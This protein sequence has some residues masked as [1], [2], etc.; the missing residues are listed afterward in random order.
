[1]RT[2]GLR[3]EQAPP[4][5]I[6][7][8]FFLTAPLSVTVVGAVLLRSG[9][10]ALVSGWSPA[11]LAI[12]HLGTL[13]FLG[14]VM[15][16]ALYQ[17]TPV[18]AGSPV[19]WIRVA[20][21]VHALLL[22]GTAGLVTGIARGAGGHVLTGVAGLGTAFLLF[23]GPVGVALARAPTRS[24]TVTGMRAALASLLLTIA[25]GLWM[26][27]GH[28]GLGFP[29]PRP[30]WIQ[31]HLCAGL[32]GWVGGLISAV[33]WQVLPMFYL[34]PPA[35]RSMQRTIQTSLGVGVLLPVAVLAVDASGVTDPGGASAS[36]VAGLAALPAVAAVWGLHPLSSL[37]CLRRRRRRR[38]DAS[39]HF[40][41][42]GLA[43]GLVSG[44]A[45]A[46]A[47]LL[48]G[49]RW[50]L[51]LGWLAV[52]GWAGMIVHGMLTRIVPFLV[53][54]HR[55]A[56]LVGGVEV[57]S[58]RSLLPDRW[59]RLGFALHLASLLAGAAAILV[60]ADA[61]ARLTGLL[62]LATASSLAH[63]LV[64]VALRKP[65]PAAAAPR[66]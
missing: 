38:V 31:V 45:A 23:L 52:W 13:G 10:T 27:L 33:S 11:T 46:A 7:L 28:A 18:V 61:L 29:G 43:I 35:S 30:L 63:S 14:M 32:L 57:P 9:A 3:L 22:L 19:P 58:A 55:Y 36:L 56:P 1:V 17:M 59:T 34:T 64:R 26:A 53:W 37:G 4:L 39:L 6:P 42:V 47:L 16:G 20:H 24:A 5:A 48:P 49:P 8:A 15:L 60:G 21:A 40:W 41:R 65:E 12:A 44:P 51:L 50:G 66:G 62:L 25:L 54:F 2:A